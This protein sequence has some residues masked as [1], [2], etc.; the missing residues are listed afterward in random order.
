MSQYKLT[1][2]KVE[3]IKNEI[4][5]N[6]CQKYGIKELAEKY[7]VSTMQI[8]RIARGECWKDVLPDYKRKK[9]PV[10]IT[11]TSVVKQIVS[12]LKKKNVVQKEVAKRFGVTE[13]V[14]SRIK[15]KHF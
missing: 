12:A 4:F 15:S 8:T 3:K 9:K 1:K 7:G 6:K 10:N 5:R 13:S 14:V 11:P 2:S